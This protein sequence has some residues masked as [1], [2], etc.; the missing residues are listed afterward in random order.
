MEDGAYVIKVDE[1]KSIGIHWIAL[2]VNGTNR[3]ASYDAIYFDILRV[4]QI[5]KEIEK[6]KRNK[7]IITNICRIQA[8][9][10]VMWE[11]FCINFI[12]F[13]LKSKSLLDYTNIFSPNDYE[14]NNK[15][16]LKYLQ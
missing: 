1:Y 16:I 11:Y 10:L 14:K 8:Y 15:M 3:R 5:L 4:E 13:M 7:N 12:D 9:N 6:F 2:D